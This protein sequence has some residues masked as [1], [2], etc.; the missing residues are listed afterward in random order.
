MDRA[1]P[2]A[3][4]ENGSPF[5]LNNEIDH[6]MDSV[7]LEEL[8]AAYESMPNDLPTKL[9]D[10]ELT[11]EDWRFLAPERKQKIYRRVP[12]YTRFPS[13]AL[14]TSAPRDRKGRMRSS[15]TFI[16]TVA[17]AISCSFSKAQEILTKGE[18][19]D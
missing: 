1:R 10:R 16:A 2:L 19:R 17:R 15:F 12:C 9:C 8:Q 5:E 4:H 3:R 7:H 18:H 6:I 14:Q 11:T 13:Q